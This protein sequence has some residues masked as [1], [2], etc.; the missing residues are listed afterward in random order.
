MDYYQI[1]AEA[2]KT[3]GAHPGLL[4][5][6]QRCK[7]AV[8]ILDVGCGEGSRLSTLLP[9]GK[10]GWGVDVNKKVIIEARKKYPSHKFLSYDGRKLPYE[11]NYFDLVY[12]AFVLEHTQ[13][14]DL[15]I[16]ESLRVCKPGG[17][18]VIICPNYGS[19]NRRSPVS[20]EN[21]LIKFGLGLIADFWWKRK[22]VW[23]KVTPLEYYDFIDA[24]TTVEPYLL[25]LQKYI[26]SIGSTI[27]KSSSLWELEPQP[28]NLRK[29]LFLNLG[30]AG[31][32]PFKYWGPQVY[33]VAT[34]GNF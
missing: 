6:V 4:D 31:I 25:F 15:F 21:P 2:S 20:K 24:D 27:I 8:R 1:A 26:N 23:S 30:K 18:F 5:L 14:P 3:I 11:D 19:P 29:R 22:L 13:D 9:P 7:T 34:K 16:S 33:L 10:C 17:T 12:T 28:N 32:F